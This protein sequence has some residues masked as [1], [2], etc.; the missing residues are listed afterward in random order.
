[1]KIINEF[2]EFALRGSVID[3]AV[4]V[5]IGSAF[6]S[7]VTSLT[8]DIIM[9]PIGWLIGGIDFSNLKF[10]MP[11]QLLG[12]SSTIVYVSYG[13]FIQTIIN[14]LIIA[15]S[16][17]FAVRLMNRLKHKEQQKPAQNLEP[18]PTPEELLLAE[19]RDLLKSQQK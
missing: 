3:L 16:I 6:G 15:M 13:K 7:I 18:V 11:H 2:K 17:F 12:D 1:M 9:P 4:G 19:I 8:N 5:I 10:A 14:F